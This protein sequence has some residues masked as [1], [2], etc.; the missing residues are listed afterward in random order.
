MLCY[1]IMYTV[2]HCMLN[3]CTASFNILTIFWA[4]TFSLSLYIHEKN[5]VRTVLDNKAFKHIVDLNWN[6][7]QKELKVLGNVSLF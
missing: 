5:K 7:L 3:V 4:G 1:G 2:A 6:N